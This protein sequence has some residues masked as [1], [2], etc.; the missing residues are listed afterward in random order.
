MENMTISFKESIHGCSKQVNFTRNENCQ[1]CDGTGAKPNAKHSR[2]K[3]CQGE[4][5]IV[6]ERDIHDMMRIECADCN[7]TGFLVLACN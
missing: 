4:G 5:H 1:A 3:V 6:E 7:G 2:C